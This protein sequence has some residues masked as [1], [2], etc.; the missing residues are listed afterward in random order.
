MSEGQA[1]IRSGTYILLPNC[2]ML[3]TIRS[4]GLTCAFAAGCDEISVVDLDLRHLW[5]FLLS[6]SCRS[7]SAAEAFLNDVLFS[8][9]LYD[10]TLFVAE[11]FFFNFHFLI[12]YLYW[13]SLAERETLANKAIK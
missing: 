12:W 2:V 5:T 3:P 8:M 10:A 7:R 11:L 1:Q 13:G 9:A 4:T 6:K